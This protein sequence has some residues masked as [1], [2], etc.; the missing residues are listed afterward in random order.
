VKLNTPTT[1][2]RRLA[3]ALAATASFLGA[4]PGFAQGGYPNKPIRMIVPLAAGSAVDVAARLLAQ[5]MS[6]NMGQSIVVENIV[7]ASGIIGADKLAKSAPDG[8]TIGGFNDSVLT[9]TRVRRSIRSLTSR[10]F[11]R[12][13]PSSSASR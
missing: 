5:K 7:G 3:I 13:R 4:A 6:E 11:P 8:Y 10:I 12:W 1:C 2:T 9:S